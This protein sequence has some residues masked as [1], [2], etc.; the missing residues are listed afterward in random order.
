MSL[1]EAEA[2]RLAMLAEECAEVIQAV[3][4]ILRF[5]WRDGNYDNRAGLETELTDVR[6]MMVICTRAG[7]V[8]P[9][10][11]HGVS[12]AISKKLRFARKQGRA[13]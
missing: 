12:N 1:T 7:D 11:P 9:E 13:S 10:T 5:G 4:K 2:E 8:N 3:S 6:A